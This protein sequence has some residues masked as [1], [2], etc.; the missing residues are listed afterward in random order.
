MIFMKL[1]KVTN[2]GV[3]VYVYVCVCMCV[4][5]CV[6]EYVYIITYIHK[7]LRMH[8]EKSRFCLVESPI[9]VVV[10]V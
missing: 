2:R 1:I 9:T 3:C 4:Y 10:V 8:I 5:V 6:C 7:H